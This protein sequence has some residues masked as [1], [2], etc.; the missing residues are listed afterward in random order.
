[1]FFCL[2]RISPDRSQERFSCPNRGN[3]SAQDVGERYEAAVKNSSLVLVLCDGRTVEVNSREDATCPRIGEHFCPHLQV[4]VSGSVTSDRPCGRRSIRAKF[5]PARQQML[6]PIFI[7]H[8]HHQVDCLAA[9][10]QSPASTRDGDRSR[11]AP[12]A[13]FCPACSNTLA[14]AASEADSYL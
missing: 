7:R 11:S 14:M 1:M 5:E 10:L 8:N 6:H 13:A 4:S 2:P 9:E 12:A 3:F